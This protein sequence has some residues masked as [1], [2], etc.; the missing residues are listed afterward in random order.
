MVATG[1]V[2]PL[3]I[4]AVSAPAPAQPSMSP[5]AVKTTPSAAA[6]G[7]RTGPAHPPS[8]TAAASPMAG[9]MPRRRGHRL[10]APPPTRPPIA[11]RGFDGLS[12]FSCSWAFGS[13]LED[14]AFSAQAAE[15]GQE[16]ALR[17][18]EERALVVAADLDHGHVGEAGLHEG[19][20]RLDMGGDV[21]A[22]GDLAGDVLLPDGL[23]GGGEVRRAG[24]F[25]HRLPPSGE[26]PELLQGP[27]PGRPGV[28]VVGQPELADA[29]LAGA[30]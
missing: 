23:G 1:P 4:R 20:G 30:A 26:P 16:L 5:A 21:G 22:A 29:G 12:E 27:L 3:T 18:V 6:T 17:P 24:Q 2:V 25:G 7:G 14:F 11:V 28:G 19:P 10:T 15:F 9:A 13:V 8:A